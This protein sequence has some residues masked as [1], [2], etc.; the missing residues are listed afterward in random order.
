MEEPV[1]RRLHKTTRS[2]LVPPAGAKV[3]AKSWVTSGNDTDEWTKEHS[4][5]GNTATA[6]ASQ[7]LLFSPFPL[8]LLTCGHLSSNSTGCFSADSFP[9]LR[10]L[11]YL[12]FN[13]FP[14]LQIPSFRSLLPSFNPGLNMESH[15]KNASTDKSVGL[16]MQIH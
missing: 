12:Q 7:L 10:P 11:L 4:R 5:K 16:A 15:T 14:T 2:S 13:G 8:P 3:A 9:F 1:R 6:S